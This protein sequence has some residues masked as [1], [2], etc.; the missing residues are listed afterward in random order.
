MRTAPHLS[1]GEGPL[2]FVRA[3]GAKDPVIIKSLESR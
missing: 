3:N 2:V 1:K